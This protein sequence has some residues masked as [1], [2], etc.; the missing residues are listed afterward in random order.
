MIEIVDRPSAERWLRNKPRILQVAFAA[1]AAF[2]V[3]ALMAM[4][5][6]TPA[7]MRIVCSSVMTAATASVLRREEIVDLARR[8]FRSF[9]DEL[10]DPLPTVS[11]PVE[12]VAEATAVVFRPGVMLRR[13]ALA[14]F[15][16]ADPEMFA[17]IAPLFYRAAQLDAEHLRGGGSVEALFT[18]PAW[19]SLVLA[20]Q[21]TT[22]VAFVRESLVS[23]DQGFWLNWFDAMWRGEPLDW[24]LQA[25]VADIVW[26][27]VHF[28]KEAIAQMVARHDLYGAARALDR[29]LERLNLWIAY[30]PH[31]RP[32][33]IS[34]DP[35]RSAVGQ[36]SWADRWSQGLGNLAR[37]WLPN[38]KVILAS[39]KSAEID[40]ADLADDMTPRMA[41]AECEAALLWFAGSLELQLSLDPSASNFHWLRR[42]QQRER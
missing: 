15:P 40:T 21:V 5:D 37:Y 13:A 18:T 24:S 22:A 3:L 6:A 1:R 34:S 17:T 28:R 39:L 32:T 11:S 19:R 9:G 25:D 20:E 16:D 29:A 27:Q 35:T 38:T 41:L 8:A 33:G 14:I 10:E 23:E 36:V 30:D 26:N 4:T 42:H 31:G 12:C 7:E 2:R